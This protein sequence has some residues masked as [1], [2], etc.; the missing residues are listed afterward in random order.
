MIFPVTVAQLSYLWW[1]FSGFAND[2]VFSY[3]GTKC[4]VSLL[5]HR[6]CSVVHTLTPL[7]RDF[8]C[9]DNGGC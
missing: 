3:Y 8:G 6:H 2:N 1:L 7:M 9:L 5:Q 4:G